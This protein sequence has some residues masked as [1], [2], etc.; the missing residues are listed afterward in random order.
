MCGR[1]KARVPRRQHGVG[2][3]DG[4]RRGEMDGIE[5]GQSLFDRE[6]SGG[7]GERLVKLDDRERRPLRME[8]RGRGASR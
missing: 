3:G 5:R 1:V 7:L 2:I 8:A 4:R 6:S